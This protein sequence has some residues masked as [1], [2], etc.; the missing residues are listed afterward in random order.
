M[1]AGGTQRTDEP[2]TVL[3]VDDEPAIADGHAAVLEEEYDTRTAYR[4]E[5]ALEAMD[6]A[7]DAVVLDRRMPGMTGK[8]VLEAI[9]DAGYDCRVVMLTGVEPDADVVEM[10]FD[11]YVVKPIDEG[12]LAE[13]IDELLTDGTGGEDEVLDALGDPKVRR[14]CDALIEEPL[15]ASELAEATGYSLPTVYRRLNALTQAG[16]VETQRAVDPEGGHYRTFVAVPTRVHVEIAD[17]VRVDV[18]RTDEGGA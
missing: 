9:R 16:I 2:P 15:S 8:E 3:L 12:E 6:D 7:V 10:G 5:A 17:R 4:G 11:A 13:T 18:R 1:E 14:C